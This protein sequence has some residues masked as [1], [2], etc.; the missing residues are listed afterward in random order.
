MKSRPCGSMF[1]SVR[2]SFRPGCLEQREQ[3]LHRLLAGGDRLELAGELAVRV[4]GHHHLG[5][6]VLDVPLGELRLERR[7]VVTADALE[8][9]RAELP[10]GD[11]RR[12]LAGRRAVAGVLVARRLRERGRG[13]LL[14][15]E[16]Q[17]GRVRDIGRALRLACTAPLAA[18]RRRAAAAGGGERQA[19]DCGQRGQAGAPLC[20]KNWHFP[21]IAS[22]TCPMQGDLTEPRGRPGH[23]ARLAGDGASRRS[24]GLP[25][26]PLDRVAGASPGR[27][28]RSFP[29]AGWGASRE[30]VTRSFPGAGHREFPRGRSPAGRCSGPL[31]T[32]WRP[33]P[34]DARLGREPRRSHHLYDYGFSDNPA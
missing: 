31:P 1:G 25:E 19:G 20:A 13:D 24:I 27:V 21:T 5:A 30:R 23:P 28:T 9:V 16:L 2:P 3:I 22:A 4:I 32:S 6:R 8:D 33:A 26:L 11:I 18:P 14:V 10:G 34:R 12:E 7:D 29:R 15:Q 17:R